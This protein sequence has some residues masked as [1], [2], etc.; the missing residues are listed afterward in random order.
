MS[1]AE[2]ALNAAHSALTVHQLDRLEALFAE[3]DAAEAEANA[4]YRNRTADKIEQAAVWNRQSS[5]QSL[6]NTAIKEWGRPL[7]A[8]AKRSL[9]LEA[10]NFVLRDALD[11]ALEPVDEA[12]KAEFLAVK[13]AAF[14]GLDEGDEP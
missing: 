7:L 14:T 6:L 5:A 1:D 9:A 13:A 3:Y 11:E 10:E 12:T 2:S 4:M 8:M